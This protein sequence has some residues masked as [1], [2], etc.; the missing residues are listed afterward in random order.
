MIGIIKKLT[1]KG[2]GFITPIGGGNDVFFHASKVEGV[3]FPEL[4]E[5]EEVEF[6]IGEGRDGR[7]A[8][9]VVSLVE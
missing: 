2:F 3:K 1:D 9:S 4:H 8:A 5:G 7:P 6:E